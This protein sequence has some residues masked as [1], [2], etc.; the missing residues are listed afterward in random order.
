MAG[1]KHF[2]KWNGYSSKGNNSHMEMFAFFSLGLLLKKRICSHWEQF[3]PLIT[4]I[5]FKGFR[6]KEGFFLYAKIV[7]LCKTMKKRKSFICIHFSYETR[8]GPD[9]PAVLYCCRD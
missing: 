8:V 7:I 9:R 2:I 6:Y 3:F 1:S 4:P 5:F